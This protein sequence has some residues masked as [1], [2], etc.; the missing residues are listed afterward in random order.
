MAQGSYIYDAFRG[1][2]KT[3]ADLINER[4]QQ[5]LQEEAF[6]DLQKIPQTT[7][8]YPTTDDGTYAFGGEHTKV[9]N[10]DYGSAILGYLSQT[11]ANPQILAQMAYQMQQKRQPNVDVF[12]GA[13]SGYYG[14]DTND[15]NANPRQL[16]PGLGYRQSS[17]QT[18]PTELSKYQNE[19]SAIRLTNP[20]DPR[21]PEYEN[22][23]KKLQIG[24]PNFQSI[25]TGQGEISTYDKKTG[26][27]T[28][29]TGTFVPSPTVVR[30]SY[31]QL[32]NV[33]KSVDKLES[34]VNRSSITGPV[35]GRA[36]K[37]GTRFFSDADATELKNV[38]GQL[39][40]I[41][42]GLSGK[43]INEAELEW[44]NTEILPNITQP[45][46]NFET[47][48][49]VFKKWLK[50]S[51]GSLEEQFPSLKPKGAPA[52]VPSEGIKKISSDEEYD[53]LPSGTLFVDPEGVQRK[54]P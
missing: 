2:G 48:L 46:E 19:L 42:Y 34:I 50:Q 36:R 20:K 49:E 30:Q 17:Q 53:A 44:L 51:Q 52:T 13:E 10:P 54:K 41:I 12:G 33:S 40:P 4:T 25:Q 21:I 43:Q 1:V 6:N 24:V 38:V 3:F 15:P 9:Q 14:L 16:V 26:R 7:T 29:G 31:S 37:I 27:L 18:Q 28:G 35:T 32:N 47:T 22:V 11:G 8:Q 23:I 39:R 45:D 5:K